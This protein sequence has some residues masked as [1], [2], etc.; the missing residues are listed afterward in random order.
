MFNAGVGQSSFYSRPFYSFPIERELYPTKQIPRLLADVNILYIFKAPN[1]VLKPVAG[2][3][4]S[5]QGYKESGRGLA[6]NDTFYPYRT[7]LKYNYINLFGGVSYRLALF[8]M[9][10]IR[11]VQ[12]LNLM[13]SLENENRLLKKIA[14]ATRTSMIVDILLKNNSNLVLI[15]FFQTSILPFNTKKYSPVSTN[16]YPFSY[17]INIG[18][19]F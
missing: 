18:S 4:Y 8:P 9:W 5:P 14:P 16:Y 15:P 7:I 19:Y 11:I 10:K 1:L 17:G 6:T 13:G 3:G 12:T 2:V